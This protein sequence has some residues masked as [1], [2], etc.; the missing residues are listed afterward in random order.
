MLVSRR[1]K[2]GSDFGKI[3]MILIGIGTILFASAC[4]KNVP[5]VGTVFLM[6]GDNIMKAQVADPVVRYA[7]FL[8]GGLFIAYGIQLQI[9]IDISNPLKVS[10][11]NAASVK[12]AVSRRKSWRKPWDCLISRG[13]AVMQQ[14]K[15]CSFVVWSRTICVKEE[16]R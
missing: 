16:Q 7:L 5:L 3:T 15:R 1:S 10:N 8:I 12:P 11:Q 9:K 4:F 14:Q 6:P 13:G 2:G